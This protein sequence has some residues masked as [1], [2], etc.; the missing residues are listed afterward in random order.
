MSRRSASSAGTARVAVVGSASAE[1]THVRA[2]L[3]GRG[4]AGARVDLY[5]VTHGEAV[6]SEYDGEAR[7]IQ[8]PEPAEVG[9]HDVVFLCEPGEASASL[10]P[11]AG[12]ASVVL[13]LVGCSGPDAALAHASLRP[14]SASERARPLRI[15]HSIS[16]VLAE[17]LRPLHAAFGVAGATAVVL[18]PAADFGEEGI[19]ELREQT[20]RLLRFERTPSR[21]FGRQLAF[22]VIPQHLLPGAAEGLERRIEAETGALLGTGEGALA[23]RLATVPVFY[24]HAMAVRLDL[25]DEAE[26]ADVERAV[27]TRAAG[28]RPVGKSGPATPMEAATA[29]GASVSHVSRAGASGFWMW[30]VAGEAE[31]ASARAA[32]DLA[33]SLAEIA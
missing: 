27:A 22:N 13:D 19:E 16:V 12:G 21:T 3:A 10:L 30:A 28:L 24:G 4:V 25:R 31:A 14:P 20:V 29:Q 5:G 18:R 32:V 1:G 26:V 23:I 2:A 33:A 15:P 17:L 9:G 8:E 6:L 7:L 11:L